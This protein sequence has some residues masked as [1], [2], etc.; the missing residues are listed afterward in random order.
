MRYILKCLYLCAI[1][2]NHIFNIIQTSMKNTFLLLSILTITWFSSCG[3]PANSEQKPVSNL[4][5]NDTTMRAK[6]EDQSKS[7]N[8]LPSA[9]GEEGVVIQLT[10]AMFEKKYTYHFEEQSK[11]WTFKGDKPCIIDLD[12]DWC[13]PCKM[14]APIMSEF[15]EKYKG[16]VIIYKVNTDQER[17]L[18]KFFNIRS[19]PTVFFLPL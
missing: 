5:G 16:Q 9:S 6:T 3:S 13:R 17:E 4:S 15:S 12:A 2:S 14:V 19:I 8:S 10:K 1:Q 18:A 11:Q 7:E